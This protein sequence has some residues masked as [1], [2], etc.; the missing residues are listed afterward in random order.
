MCA[1][2][3]IIGMIFEKTKS[4][5]RLLIISNFNMLTCF[6]MLLKMQKINYELIKIIFGVI[7]FFCSYQI[8]IIAKSIS[9]SKS[10]NPALV[11][12][13][14]NMIMMGCGYIFHRAMGAALYISWSGCSE[15]TGNPLYSYQGF[16]NIILLLIITLAI[17]LKGFLTLNNDDKSFNRL[18]KII[19]FISRI[20]NFTY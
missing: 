11:S 15:L 6:L 8:L 13:I 18:K 9:I 19:K 7:G 5:Y 14:A 10:K 4:C 2:L 12:A 1:G 16:D 20:L 3:V 17:S